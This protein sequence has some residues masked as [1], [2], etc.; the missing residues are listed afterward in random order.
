M[1]YRNF[2]L[3][4]DKD[5]VFRILN[6]CGWV[7][8]KKKDKYLNEFLPK[9]NTLVH[10]IDDEAEIMVNSSVGS[11]RYLEES[12]TFSAITGVVASLKVRKQGLSGKLTAIRMALDAEKG[13]EVSGLCIFDQGYYNKLGYANGC[14]DRIVGFTPSFLN[15]DR[16]PKI[17]VRLLDKDYKKIHKS[18]V[19][20]MPYHG[21]V[22]L[23]E[24]TTKAEMGQQDRHVGFGYF[25]NKGNLTHHIWLY[26]KGKERG[27][28]WVSWMSYQNLD[29][30]MDLLALLK[31]FEEQFIMIRLV[32]P[33]FIH[34][35][36]FMNK[37]FLVKDVTRKSDHFNVIQASSYWQIR[38]LDLIKCMGK[39]HLNCEDISFNLQ[40]SD[41][42]EKYLPK[43]MAWKGIAGDYIVTLGKNSS[44]KK[45]KN[46]NLPTMITSVEGFTRLWYGY[47]SASSLVYSNGLKAPDE[48]LKKLDKA[49]VL[50]EA[51]I[52]WGF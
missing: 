45:G 47:V 34:F 42:V 39:T 18:R 19:G 51:H 26:G 22:T 36:D 16:K 24:Y 44:A 30:L 14:Y 43:T 31:S 5:S 33:P 3:K 4:K 37:P 25:D 21:A 1:N 13:A 8:D 23:P 15:I 46:E 48:L 27:P 2:D 6:E 41:P 49:I 12:L 40:L 20:R 50:P 35:Q 11:I 17:P 28:I 29:Q 10:E 32:E 52:D 9:A 38:I 7:H